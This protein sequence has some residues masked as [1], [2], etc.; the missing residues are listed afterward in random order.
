MSRFTIAWIVWASVTLVSFA[1]IEGIA[2]YVGHGTLSA[3]IWALRES[4]SLPAR[5][6]GGMAVALVGWLLYHFLIYPDYLQGYR[7]APKRDGV[8]ALVL[9]LFSLKSAKR[10][11]TSVE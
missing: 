10:K 2:L 3:H 11:E 6:L 5:V 4:H 7:I 8:I 1:I 9:L